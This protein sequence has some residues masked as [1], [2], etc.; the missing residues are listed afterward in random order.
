MSMLQIIPHSWLPRLLAQL[1]ENGID[2]G[3]AG[4][5][6]SE[7][8]KWGGIL[9]LLILIGGGIVMMIR[10]RLRDE[11]PGSGTNP[12]F[13]LSDLRAMRDR[14]EITPEEYEQTRARVIAKVKGKAPE[15]HKSAPQQTEQDHPP[16]QPPPSPENGPP[17][18]AST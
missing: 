1:P 18:D 2:S 4:R 3:N 16:T 6:E 10:R 12:G 5:M 13:S 7:V 17:P 15:S 14:G 11:A 8:L 9:I